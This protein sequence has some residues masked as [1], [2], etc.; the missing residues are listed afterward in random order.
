MENQVLNQE[1]AKTLRDKGVDMSKAVMC[2][3]YRGGLMLGK[4]SNFYHTELSRKKYPMTNTLTV[5]DLMEM[6]PILYPTKDGLSTTRSSSS[7]CTYYPNLYHD[8][9]D[10]H[11]DY[12]SGDGD[13]VFSSKSEKAIDALDEAIIWLIDN[14]HELNQ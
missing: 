7:G 5:V 10:F 1:Q 11:V 2:H 13:S 6:M 12:I 8:G 4:E 3:D 14:N 9:D